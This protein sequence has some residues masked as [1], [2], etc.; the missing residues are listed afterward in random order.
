[1]FL[2][3]YKHELENDWVPMEM[4]CVQLAREEHRVMNRCG[5]AGSQSEAFIFAKLLP[6]VGTRAV[7]FC[8]NAS[9]DYFRM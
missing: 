6:L 3:L 2:F 5:G 8:V 4:S 9:G 7:H 1:M